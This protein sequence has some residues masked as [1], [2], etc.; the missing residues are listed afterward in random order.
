ML[1][2]IAS[3]WAFGPSYFK[4]KFHV[5]DALVIITGFALDLALHG[6]LEE[7]ASLIVVLRLWRVFKIIEELSLGAQEQADQMDLEIEKLRGESVVLKNERDGLRGA[8]EGVR[9]NLEDSRR[10]LVEVKG[11]K[12]KEAKAREEKAK[13]TRQKG[14]EPEVWTEAPEGE[15]EEREVDDRETEEAVIDD[16]FEEGE[17]EEGEYEEEVPRVR[18]FVVDTERGEFGVE[19]DEDA[20]EYDSNEEFIEEEKKSDP[21]RRGRY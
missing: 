10:E 5:V 4:S 8:L 7:A 12:A 15:I 2:L 20:V 19:I 13:D 1:E 17:G 6:D 18:K 16:D 9:K 21:E 11:E 3:I 14:K